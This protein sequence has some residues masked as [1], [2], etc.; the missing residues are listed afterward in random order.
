MTPGTDPLGG[1]GKIV[2]ADETYFGQV[3]EAPPVEAAR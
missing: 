3:E 1:S 2:E